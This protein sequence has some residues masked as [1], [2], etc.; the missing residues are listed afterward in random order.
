MDG[1]KGFMRNNRKAEVIRSYKEQEFVESHKLKG[2]QTSVAKVNP[3]I[4]LHEL[5]DSTIRPSPVQI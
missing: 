1:G 2:G 3:Q 5:K 4:M